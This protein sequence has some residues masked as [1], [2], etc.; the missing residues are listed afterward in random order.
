[1][2]KQL[3]SSS[4]DF[5]LQISMDTKSYALLVWLKGALEATSL[6]EVIRRALQVYQLIAPADE[7]PESDALGD[8]DAFSGALEPPLR[9]VHVRLPP[10]TMDRLERE[11]STGDHTYAHVVQ[12]ALRVLAQLVRERDALVANSASAEHGLLSDAIAEP[13]ARIRLFTMAIG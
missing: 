3:S 8:F 7:E 13:D 1:V 9:S 10:R 4:Q 2:G 11:R 5:Q 12:Q 6:G